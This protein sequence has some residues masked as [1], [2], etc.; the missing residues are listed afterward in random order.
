MKKFSLLLHSLPCLAFKQLDFIFLVAHIS[1]S[2]HILLF[3]SLSFFFFFFV[4]AS[5]E[6]HVSFQARA[7]IGAAA[8]AYATLVVTP[9]SLTH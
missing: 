1:V 6:A 8:A 3:L 9:R 2:N 5:P 4:I 7:Q